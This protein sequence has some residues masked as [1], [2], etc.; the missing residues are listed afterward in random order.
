MPPRMHQPSVAATL[1]K[2]RRPRPFRGVWLFGCVCFIA[3]VFNAATTWKLSS[4]SSSLDYNLNSGDKSLT[5]T[6]WMLLR[7]SHNVSKARTVDNSNDNKPGQQLVRFSHKVAQAERSQEDDVAPQNNSFAAP[8]SVS[9]QDLTPG[10]KSKMET[11]TNANT[12]STTFANK[13]HHHQ[14]LDPQH[15]RV[16]E[17][18]SVRDFPRNSMYSAAW[19]QSIERFQG[20][21]PQL[22]R[23][24]V[25]AVFVPMRQQP[26]RPKQPQQDNGRRR[27]DVYLTKDWLDFSVEHLS[28][29]W[30]TVEYDN[31]NR[32]AAFDRLMSNL[33]NY[34]AIMGHEQG[35]AAAPAPPSL[36]HRT[37]VVIAYA[38]IRSHQ[39]NTDR[40]TELD[41]VVLTSTMVSL[42]RQGMGRIVVMTDNLYLEYMLRHIW[43][44]CMS[45]L[46]SRTVDDEILESSS[47]NAN[48]TAQQRTSPS[49]WRRAF[50]ERVQAHWLVLDQQREHQFADTSVVLVS[51][52]AG[53]PVDGPSPSLADSQRRN[54]P[55]FA[56][57]EVYRALFA[58]NETS[59]STTTTENE[60]EEPMPELQEEILGDGPIDRWKYVYYTEQDS[61]MYLKPLVAP[62][63]QSRLDQG[64]MLL[65]HRLQPM[66]HQY[67]FYPPNDTDIRN[68]D[69]PNSLFL[70]AIGPWQHVI[71][72]DSRRDSC[73]DAGKDSY[74]FQT[75]PKCPGRTHNYWYLCGFR[76]SSSS[77]SSSW[78]PDQLLET[79][80]QQDDLL[81][82]QRLQ[83][84]T[85]MRLSAN[86][87]G[88]GSGSGLVHLA[89]SQHG[90]QCIPRKASQGPCR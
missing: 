46:Q 82:H 32:S 16:V 75:Y 61:L 55:R 33:L 43:P 66:P 58:A 62:Q 15:H 25:D 63:L 3:V 77:S 90:R 12:K 14:N 53:L 49:T 40:V 56:V 21:D 88:G 42:I 37:L 41:V 36:T 38:P 44:A 1:S 17:Y 64:D 5:D 79:Q 24:Q 26:K 80:Q 60:Q 51:G 70:P 59:V 31:F 81:W 7:S 20:L 11:N 76:G 47:G 34:I 87:S 39:N 73:C 4:S 52:D 23:K 85:L 78:Q 86:N 50:T 10:F 28:K 74:V 83:N 67:D 45:L 30:K 68:K 27:D 8:R 9:R 35:A 72:L 29:W 48:P 89:A 71:E 19:W 6:W 18:I 57:R 65:P 84:Y 13:N 2:G 69:P 54:V 22:V